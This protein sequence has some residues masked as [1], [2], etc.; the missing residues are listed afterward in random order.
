MKKKDKLLQFYEKNNFVSFGK[1]KLDKDETN[2]EGTCLIQLLQ[3][4]E[5]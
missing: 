3:Y 4:W 2:L 5:N 1:R